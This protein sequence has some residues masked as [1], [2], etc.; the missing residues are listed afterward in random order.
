MEH[1]RRD[2]RLY[3]ILPGL[4]LG[5]LLLPA[6][7]L[8]TGP[9]ITHSLLSPET[10]EIYAVESPPLFSMEVAQQGFA[11]EI[12]ATALS[13]AGIDAA[14]S[15][16][17]L[18][19]MVRYYLLQENAIAVTGSDLGFSA[20]EKRE[21]IFIPVF[22]TELKYIYYKPANGGTE[23][24][25]GEL[26]NLK[27]FRYGAFEGENVSAYRN[28]GIQVE[29]GRALPLLKSLKAGKV[30]FIGLPGLTAAWLIDRHFPNEQDNFGAM[31]PAAGELPV[32]IIFNKKHPQGEAAANKFSAALANMLDDGRY[33]KILEK[34]LGKSDEL[35]EQMKRLERIRNK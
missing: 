10:M 30:D 28:A 5:A 34:H 18:Q 29:E 1:A 21:L 16:L 3:R 19:K 27:G 26:K 20:D 8:A 12:V 2:K 35:K 24:W 14:I 13:A 32:Y 11:S 33:L 6:P 7:A 15:I 31:Q 25:N 4:L 22:V 9:R 17:P 23:K